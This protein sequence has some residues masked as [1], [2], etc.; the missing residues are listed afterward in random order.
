MKRQGSDMNDIETIP[1]ANGLTVEIRDLSRP[2]AA[3]TTKVELLF[4]VA[5]PLQREDC[6][7][8]AHY[9]LIRKV[10]GESPRFEYRG[11]RSFVRNTNV[12]RAARELREA[13]QQDAL[14]YLARPDFPR[15]FVRAKYREIE[16]QP[17]RYREFLKEN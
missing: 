8:P 4:S 9:E 14:S 16:T 5:V 2:I 12:E 7:C 17:Y 6:D 10:W 1:L 13:F 3:D 15:R 11:T